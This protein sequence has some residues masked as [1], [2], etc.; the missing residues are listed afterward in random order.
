MLKQ[1][2]FTGLFLCAATGAQAACGGEDTPCITENGDYHISMPDAPQDAPVVVFLHGYGSHGMASQN[3]PNIAG[4][5]LDRGYAL[6]SP[7]ALKE[8]RATAWNFHPNSVQ[9]RD[10][11]NFLSEVIQD[12]VDQF[13]LDADRVLLAGFS[14][15]GSMTSYVACNDP[16]GY[17]AF[18]PVAG[19]FWRPEPAHCTAPIRLLHTH[20]WADKTV[21]IEGRE[22]GSGFIQGNVF[23]AF[24]TLRLANECR[25]PHAGEMREDGVFMRR[26]WT[27][28]TP[29]TALELA[30]FPGGHTVPAGWADMAL[31]WFEALP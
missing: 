11:A 19:S 17:A 14:L 3:N 28:C 20:G 1:M 9:G 31:D 29:D 23:S 2:T 10:E 7:N 8:G 22:V 15:G 6:I 24:E 5:I 18:A 16:D 25:Q 26:K 4:D 13:G 21:P 27:D 12:A 30:L